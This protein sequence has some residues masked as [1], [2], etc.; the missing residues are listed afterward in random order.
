MAHSQQSEAVSLLGGDVDAQSATLI[1][2]HGGG[3][4][5]Y[6]EQLAR[7]D[8][9][10]LLDAEPHLAL[11]TGVVP[12]A[13]AASLAEE[14]AA[15]ASPARQLLEAAAVSGEPFGLDVVAAVAEL[16]QPELLEA[17]SISCW[18]L[19]WSARPRFP[20]DSSFAIR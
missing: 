14:F 12:K 8:Q 10:A 1:Y 3:N 15:L 4:P 11:T 5:F 17:L 9:P 16:G 20:G 19:T 13:V 7:M 6:L 18:K 2:R